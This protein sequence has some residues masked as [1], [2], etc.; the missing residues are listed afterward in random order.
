MSSLSRASVKKCASFVGRRS[1]KKTIHKTTHHLLREK[2]SSIAT[3]TTN[4]LQLITPLPALLQEADSHVQELTGKLEEITAR[5]E[6]SETVR[7]K[8]PASTCRERQQR[9][10][11]EI[12]E[13]KAKVRSGPF[14][15]HADDG[16]ASRTVALAAAGGGVGAGAGSEFTL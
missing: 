5:H 1:C 4:L 14:P 3:A 11:K 6:A 10:K 2:H 16:R 12:L 8:M 9:L 13:L 15:A 7:C